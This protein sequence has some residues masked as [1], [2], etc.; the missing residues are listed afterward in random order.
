MRVWKKWILPILKGLAVLIVVLSLAKIAFFPGG[1][2][3][4]AT[5]TGAIADPAVSPVIGTVTNDLSIKATVQEDEVQIGKAPMN[6]VIQEVY[7]QKGAEVTSGQVIA[8]I[9][10]ETPR[11]PIQNEDGSVTQQE[12]EVSWGEVTAPATG[13]VTSLDIIARQQ[14][15]AG[16][17]AVQVTP[18]ALL[19]AGT[20][21]PVQRYRLSEQPSEG[22]VT[23]QGGPATFTCTDLRI[24]S[25]SQGQS[26]AAAGSDSSG[27]PGAPGAPGAAAGGGGA[28]GSANESRVSCRVPESV[29]VFP[30]LEATLLIHG[31]IA[32]NVLT[33][34]V[35]AVKGGSG[36]GVVIVLGE[37]EVREERPV[38]LG[39]SDG[40]VVEIVEGVAEHER[41]LEFFPGA[42]APSETCTI[43]P[44]TG[45]EYCE[46]GASG[47]PGA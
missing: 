8:S 18:S 37:G 27:Q 13:T 17:T 11:D 23:I 30:G 38:V 1:E 4:G 22:Q 25:G 32:E 14:V 35:T 41:V 19:V 46:Q 42:T 7:V 29:Q 2:E 44:T 39:M 43:D 28:G 47:E 16:E 9:R 24:S 5:P 33:L 15:T 21:P 31:G 10:Q 36:S 26:G 3:E 40:T 6:G 20:I 12:P 45:E 34:P